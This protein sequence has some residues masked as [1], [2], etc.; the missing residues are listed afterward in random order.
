M[1]QSQNIG[2]KGQSF[3]G[4]AGFAEEASYGESTAPS[5]FCD[6]VSDGFEEDNAIQYLSTI[7]SRARHE[8]VGGAYEDSGS[9]DVVAAPENG[10]GMLLKAGF[11]EATVTTSDPDGDGT[12]EVGTHTFTTAEFL[13]SLS[14]ELGLG[15]VGAVRHTGVGVTTLELSHTA[16]EFLTG[17]ID[18]PAQ[19]PEIQDTQAAPTYSALRSFIYHDGSF[20]VDGTDRTVDLQELTFSLENNLEGLY[21]DARGPSKMDLGTREI[22]CEGT[23]DFESMDLYE[24]MLGK[25]GATT[26]QDEVWEGS[27]SA[28]WTSPETI[29]DTT[30]NYSL[31]LDMPRVVMETHDAQLNER[32]LIAENVTF[33]LL[34][35]GGAAYDAQATL[36]N[37]RTTA[38]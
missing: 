3:L 24:R 22:T 14:V 12:E 35:D 2:T 29:D 10:L 20:S 33:G 31:A 25:A 36:V 34:H 7:R 21:R 17:S 26:P 9:V 37:S 30:E 27:L 15:Q 11:G 5:V 4:Y 16:E 28:D 19:V 1:S 18:M 6:V 32:D 23:L 8:G 13:P 38:Y